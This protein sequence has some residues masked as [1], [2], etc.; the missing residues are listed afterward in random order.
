[1]LPTLRRQM[2]LSSLADW[3]R[4]GSGA[5]RRSTVA[6][7]GAMLMVE[8]P[9]GP[10]PPNDSLPPMVTLTARKAVPPVSTLSASA[11]ATIC[12]AA[13]RVTAKGVPT[14]NSTL[15]LISSPS[16]LGKN[17]NRACPDASSAIAAAG[18]AKLTSSVR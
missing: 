10:T 18:K 5:R 1:M 7:L 8:V 17:R 2:R 3:V 16:R 12:S 13:A 15:A 14:G 9:P 4:G 6:T 11:A